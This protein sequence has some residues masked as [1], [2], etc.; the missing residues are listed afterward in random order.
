[1]RWFGLMMV[2]VG[3]SLPEARWVGEHV[4]IAADQGLVPCGDPA[5]H[6]DAY[7]ELVAAELRVPAPTGDDRIAYYWLHREGFAERT[8]CINDSACSLQGDV[9][10]IAMPLDHE[11]VHALVRG[12]GLPSPFFLEG[13]A[14]AYELALPGDPRETIEIGQLLASTSIMEAIDE[15]EDAWLPARHY[16][17]AGAFTAFLIER[18]GIDAVLRVY[19]ESRLLDGVG[20]VARVFEEELGESLAAA[21]AAFEEGVG[22]CSLRAYRLKRFECAAPELAW[23][24]EQLRVYETIACDREDVVGPFAG[25]DIAVFRTLEVQADGVFA[26]SLLGDAVAGA[27]GRWNRAILARCGG[28]DG[29][30]EQTLTAADGTVEAALPAGRYSLQLL[31]PADSATGLGLRVDRIADRYP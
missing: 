16:P 30:A 15:R 29:Y 28:C 27:D 22:N 4:E 11:L 17:L 2:L 19:A 26:L 20:R 5:G 21:A 1:M 31:G 13:L 7:I 18:H 10:A 8:I 9:Y 23:D 25:D 14:V 3:C 12:Y 24:G 6:M